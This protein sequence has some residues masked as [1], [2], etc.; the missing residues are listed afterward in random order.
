MSVSYVIKHSAVWATPLL[1]GLMIDLIQQPPEV[2][3]RW[4]WIYGGILALVLVQMVPM[5]VLFV[6]KASKIGRGTGRRL[7]LEVC[8]QLQQLS[9]LYHERVGPGRL[10]SKLIREINFI[11]V[12]PRQ[13]G[14]TALNALTVLTGTVVVVSFMAPM[15]LLLFAVMFPDR[16][17][18]V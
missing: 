11:E 16:K 1:V 4:L 6:K 17:S 8:R 14:N 3:Y 7:R 9:L 10:Q 18:V 12:F 2:A 15:A 5:S 13:F